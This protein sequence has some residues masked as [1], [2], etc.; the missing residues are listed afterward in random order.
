MARKITTPLKFH[1][2]QTSDSALAAI[3]S[4][5]GVRLIRT[6]ELER[7]EVDDPGMAS[8]KR[9]DLRVQWRLS[10]KQKLVFERG[11]GPGGRGALC[12]RIVEIK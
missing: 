8:G 2:G 12:Y 1:I 6:Q 3:K 10:D 4:K 5:R 9:V 11:R 7:K